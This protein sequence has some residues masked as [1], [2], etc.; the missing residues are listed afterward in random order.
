MNQKNIYFMPY[1]LNEV[2][3]GIVKLVTLMVEGKL[4]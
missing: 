4:E 3:E 1:I 2:N